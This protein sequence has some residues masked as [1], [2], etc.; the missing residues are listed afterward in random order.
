MTRT[1]VLLGIVGSALGFLTPAYAETIEPSDFCNPILGMI[2]PLFTLEFEHW[3][4]ALFA[5]SPQGIC[6]VEA[7][8][9]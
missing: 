8:T 1:L 7:V 4:A 5:L 9:S 2:D 3:R 6:S